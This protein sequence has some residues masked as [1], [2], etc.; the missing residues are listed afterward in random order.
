MNKSHT[1]DETNLKLSKLL[2]DKIN[3]EEYHSPTE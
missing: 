2:S 1:E 3:M